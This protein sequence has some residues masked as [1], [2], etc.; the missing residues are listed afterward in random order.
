MLSI[1]I[2]DDD[3]LTRRALYFEIE[4]A[5]HSAEAACDAYDGLKLIEFRNY[6]L[7]ICDIILPQI[8]GLVFGTLLKQ[9]S[10]KSIPLLLMSSAKE[11]QHI[12]S[13][14]DFGAIGFIQKPVKRHLLNNW[15]NLV[16]E[17]RG[18]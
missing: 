11:M 1:L 12:I 2:I 6:D 16:E 4:R 5:G 18:L 10:S 17:M 15:L 8:S 9:F 14:N 3:P 7:I 13:Q